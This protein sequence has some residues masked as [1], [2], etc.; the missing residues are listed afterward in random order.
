MQILLANPQRHNLPIE[1]TF[2]ISASNIFGL[3]Q[4]ELEDFSP[5]PADRLEDASAWI[6]GL[7]I[8]SPT[9]GLSFP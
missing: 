9:Q 8:G 5:N 6:L 1:E 2:A 4:A 7:K 3:L